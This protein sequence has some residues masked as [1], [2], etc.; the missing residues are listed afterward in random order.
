MKHKSSEPETSLPDHNLNGLNSSKR[1]IFLVVA[2][3][4]LS[5]IVLGVWFYNSLVPPNTLLSKLPDPDLTG[6]EQQVIE[7]VE[8][9]RHALQ[10]NLK[11]DTT[12]GGL[13][14]I[15]D[16]HGLKAESIPCYKQAAALNPND[17]N[18]AYF[19]AI[20]LRKMGFSEALEFFE[21]STDLMR[22]YLPLQIRYGQA[23][24][25][26]DR[27]EDALETFEYAVSL[28]STSSHAHLGLAQV[29]FS[30]VEF[31]ASLTHL[32][33]TLELNPRHREAHA[34]TADV[35]RRLGRLDESRKEME[36]TQRLPLTTSIGDSVYQILVAE[37]VSAFWHRQRGF[38][39]LSKE[40]L[41]EGF[42]ELRKALALKPDPEGHN[43]VGN[44]LSQ[45]G[46]YDEAMSEY[47]KAISLAPNYGP[48]YQN[49]G[50]TLSK[51]G[52]KEEAVLWLE[53]SLRLIPK[54]AEVYLDLALIYY[55]LK[56]PNDTIYTLR[57]GLNATGGDVSIALRLAWLLATESNA[58]LRSG[59]EA[60]RIAKNV[61]ENTSYEDPESMDVL[62]AAYA[63]TKEFAAAALL[64]QK[65]AQ[66]ALSTRQKALA[67]RIQSRQELYRA[68]KPYRR[69]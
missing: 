20:V 17:F 62:A 49:L 25:D 54:S 51:V 22:D 8:R 11:S 16:V 68:G 2:L 64:A 41:D 6:M 60:V 3:S 42:E 34:M 67:D 66:M 39:L 29:A 9:R 21:K 18:W 14:M 33:K 32:T 50:E 59:A 24:I 38:A 13:A 43:S 55:K 58:E 61:C 5:S 7:E 44:L 63:E 15:L 36:I 56:R 4:V 23:L 30:R 1:V 37:G 69:H 52:R 19:C 40:R 31:E 48:P 57:R 65:A 53:K 46:R 26:A 47:H 35:L 10:Q 12:W 28:D 45:A 27:L